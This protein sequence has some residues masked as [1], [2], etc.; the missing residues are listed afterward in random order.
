MPSTPSKTLSPAE[1]AKLE[2]AF[3]TD[4]AS[5]AYQPLAEAYLGMGRFMEAMVVCKKGVKAH[6]SA[7]APRV[8][9]A[10][11]YA[12]QGKDKKALEELQGALQVAPNDKHALRMSGALLFKTGDAESGKTHLLKAYE[13]DP[14]DAE[15]QALLSQH[16]VEIPAPARAAPAAP[17]AAKAGPPVLTPVATPAAPGAPRGSNGAAAPQQPSRAAPQRPAP[18]ARAQTPAPVPARRPPPRA[19]VPVDDEDDISD[20]ASGSYPQVRRKSAKRGIGTFVFLLL[21]VPVALGAYFGI[22]RMKAKEGREMNRLFREA[23]ELLRHDSYE[24]Y[25]KA[26]EILEKVLDIQPSSGRA[27]GGLAYAYAIRWGEHAGDFAAQAKEHL[28][29]AK[30][31]GEASAQLYAAEALIQTYSGQGAQALSQLETRLKELE[32]KEK[33]KPPLLYLTLGLIQMN[34]GDL[35]HARESLETAQ[36][37]ASDDPRVYAALGT[38]YRRR[39]QDQDAWRNFDFALRYRP[40]HPD[41]MLGKA[42]LSLEQEEPGYVPTAKIL[43]RL[44]ESQP[45]PSKRQLA[46]AHLA[47]AFLVS[48]LSRE[49]SQYRPE[50]QRELSE[51]TGVTSD[52]GKSK[53]EIAR[54]EETGFSLDGKNP[55]LFLIKGKRLL[56][57]DNVDGAVAEIRRAIEIDQSRAHYHVELARA[58]MRKDGG[59]KEAEGALKKALSMNPGSPKL[60]AMLG[61]VFMRLGK[62]D[63][64]LREFERAVSGPNARNPE[65]RLSMGRIYREKRDYAKA[66]AA[67]EKAAQE[68]IGQTYKIAQSYDELALAYDAKGDKAKAQEA[69]EKA[70]NADKDYEDAYCHYAKFLADEPRNRTRARAFA[71]EYLKRAPRGSCAAD[72]QRLA[73]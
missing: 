31:S 51:G 35:E 61:Q 49:L 50:A 37:Y 59:E 32:A 67:L 33:V 55:E 45:P 2:H 66:I 40:D 13:V 30:E 8:L 58:L 54:Q 15:T 12:E 57:E 21:A 16:K 64:A 1:L 29:A 68:Y 19:H 47:R 62:H 46:T 20:S 70:L 52:A 36:A 56:Y 18:A 63:D 14:N 6:P 71:Q 26:C 9:L 3:A 43:K 28:E 11:V 25:K 10:R 5:D 24:S 27:H 17:A 65:A 41:S 48:R 34:A 53:A 42:L 7:S 38:L 23:D 72:A 73:R 60:V 4:P 39:G 69:F 22:G 44:L